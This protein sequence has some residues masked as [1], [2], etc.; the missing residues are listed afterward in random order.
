MQPSA[1]SRPTSHVLDRRG[2]RPMRPP[3]SQAPSL[4]LS[5][6]RHALLLL[7]VAAGSAHAHHGYDTH[8][9]GARLLTMQGR[10]VSFAIENPHTRIVIEV[11][12]GRGVAETWTVETVPASRAAQLNHPLASL[13]LKPGDPVSVAGWP[14]RDGS[15]RLGGHKLILSDGRE[16][17]LRP[18]INLPL[19]RE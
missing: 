19:R 1:R 14:A 2:P 8:Y 18:A 10:L 4:F 3:A 9:G 5:W 17:M 16:I 13:K 11:R 15:K 7:L 6:L 12:D